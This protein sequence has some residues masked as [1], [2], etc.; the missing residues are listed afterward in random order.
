M[1]DRR[2][3]TAYIC[4]SIMLILS[5]IIALVLKWRQLPISPAGLTEKPAAATE[6]T[7]KPAISTLDGNTKAGD[8]ESGINELGLGLAVIDPAALVARIGKALEVGDLDT[9]AKL[10]GMRLPG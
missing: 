10:I 7:N 8:P 6:I 5:G 3:K 9:A 4:L 1:A 2:S